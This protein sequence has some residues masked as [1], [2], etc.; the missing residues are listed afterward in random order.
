MNGAPGEA[1]ERAPSSSF[2][3]MRI[4]DST[5][6]ERLL[7]VDDAQAIDLLAAR[8]GLVDDGPLALGELERGAHGLERQQDVREEDRRVDAEAQRL[9]RDLT[10]SSG[11]LQSSSSVCF[12]RSLRYS[13][14]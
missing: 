5:Y 14:M 4:A 10:A 13:G 2:L 8:D 6:G 3:S 12:S 7:G 11:V 9:Q 1:D